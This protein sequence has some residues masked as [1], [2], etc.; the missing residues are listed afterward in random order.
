[1]A[2]SGGERTLVDG[3]L[4]A[5]RF[6]E[7]AAEA[8]ERVALVGVVEV[9]LVLAC[10]AGHVEAGLRARAGERYVTPFLKPRLARAEDEGAL[11]G[12][13]LG[14][15][16]GEGVGV[17]E[18][19]RVEVAATE[20]D[21]RPA[22]GRNDERP[23]FGV[24]T[25]DSPTRS[26]LDAEN[27]GVAETDD[28]VTRGELSFRDNEPFL[29]EP[30]GSIHQRPGEL[31]EISHVAAAK[32]EHDVAGEVVTRLLP[33]VGEHSRAG[34]DRT[35]GDDETLA[36]LG[37]GEVVAPDSTPDAGKSV[38]LEIV[39][40]P[41]V[42][43][44]DDGAFPL[45]DPGEQPACPDGWKLVRIADEDR[46]SVRLFDQFENGGEDTRLRHARLVD[47]E[48]GAGRQAFAVTR[49]VE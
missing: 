2:R 49:A 18:V 21:D 30:T 12:E 46:L 4:L 1:M 15:V 44:Q 24:D 48:D 13:A 34:G 41:A 17:A 27:I 10:S 11:D 40:L 47:D 38:A 22:V 28:S 3:E 19:A 16:T 45:D 33:P 20:L 29:P 31:V 7:R 37:E 8:F 36:L 9:A 26:V 39:A 23:P 32:G 35:F 43:G 14:G 6:F 25:L 5:S 42:L